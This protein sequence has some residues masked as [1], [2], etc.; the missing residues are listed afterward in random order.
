MISA[1][2]HSDG[3][4]DLAI[5]AVE[6]APPPPSASPAAAPVGSSRRSPLLTNEAK[7]RQ[8]QRYKILRLLGVETKAASLASR[9]VCR[10][11][12]TLQALGVKP[13]QHRVLCTDRRRRSH[14]DRLGAAHSL[15]RYR[16]PV[17]VLTVGAD[18]GRLSMPVRVLLEQAGIVR[19]EA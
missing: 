3:A 15:P 10:F 16:A 5:E 11:R 13:A 6:V 12:D 4:A 7:R 18:L 14:W 1:K 9:A 8:R 2:K 17:P 19:G